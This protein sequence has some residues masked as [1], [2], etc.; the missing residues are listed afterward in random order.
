MI[1]VV[2]GVSKLERESEKGVYSRLLLLLLLL[3]LCCAR[4]K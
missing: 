2:K 4:V 3:P 1:V